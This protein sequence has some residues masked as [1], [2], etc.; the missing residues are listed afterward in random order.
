MKTVLAI[1][2][3]NKNWNLVVFFFLNGCRMRG[4]SVKN[5]KYK[6]KRKQ[7]R[8]KRLYV[9]LSW[10]PVSY[11]SYLVILRCNVWGLL[12]IIALVWILIGV[13]VICSLAFI[14]TCFPSEF[15]QKE[16]R[17]KKK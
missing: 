11:H 5:I 9:S 17:I 6:L 16:R 3:I 8:M 2:A 7:K 10:C 12:Y 13:V 15:P 4:A 1:E 14:S